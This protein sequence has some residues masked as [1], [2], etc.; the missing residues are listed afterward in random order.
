MA[1]KINAHTS[2][3]IDDG[4]VS[5]DEEI[6]TNPDINRNDI[7]FYIQDLWNITDNYPLL[8]LLPLILMLIIAN[9]VIPL[10]KRMNAK[11]QLGL[12]LAAIILFVVHT[13]FIAP[14]LRLANGS[15][16]LFFTFH[17]IFSEP[18]TFSPIMC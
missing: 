11:I 3:D 5:I 8:R 13:I 12:S 7:A 15:F 6:L 10:K 14:E 1:L 18:L 16:L 17:F 9:A 2:Y 4:N